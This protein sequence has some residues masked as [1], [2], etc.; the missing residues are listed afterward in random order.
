MRRPY[1]TAMRKP[2][3][4]VHRTRTEADTE[5]HLAIRT[6]MKPPDTQAITARTTPIVNISS[7]CIGSIEMLRSVK[8]SNMKG[9]LQTRMTPERRRIPAMILTML[10]LS[11]SMMAERKMVTTGQ[12]KMM[13]SASGTS[14]KE[15]QAR[16][17]MKAKDPV[18]PEEIY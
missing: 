15:T 16:E 10:S 18:R 7:V 4:A 6:S 8:V 3:T 12:A 17:Q 11:L 14:M 5:T 9:G 13:L 1:V 2:R